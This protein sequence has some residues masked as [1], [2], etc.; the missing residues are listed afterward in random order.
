M[1]AVIA[2]RRRE[3][4]VFPEISDGTG[5]VLLRAEQVREAS[6][7]LAAAFADDPAW[8]YI[9]PDPERRRRSMPWLASLNLRMA[10]PY[11][12]TFT[13]PGGRVEGI[14]AFYPPGR[15][16]VPL[17]RQLWLA[18]AMP[19]RLSLRSIAHV[20]RFT[21]AVERVHPKDPQ[22]WYLSILAVAPER[23]RQGVGSFL[24]APVL[25]RAD[26][27]G[28]AV[29]LETT[30]EENLAYYPRFGFELEGDFLV[31]KG[32]PRVWTLLRRPNPG[33]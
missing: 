4:A 29:Y 11:G 1:G 31:P 14:A 17:L 27:E 32:G 28:A 9:L 15:Y 26:E 2:W 25:Q 13:T 6:H 21:A 20:L 24:M 18:R 8:V 19:L 10:L 5:P 22:Q 33:K 23:Q 30:K 16:P 12:A 7:V 3:D